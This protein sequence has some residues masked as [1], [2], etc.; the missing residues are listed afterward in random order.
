MTVSFSG[1][2]PE[3]HIK[4]I[5][6]DRIK[7]IIS[8]IEGVGQVQTAGGLDREIQVRLDPSSLAEYGISYQDVCAGIAGGAVTEPAGYVSQRDDRVSLR[9]IGAFESIEDLEN[10]VIPA[11]D[12]QPVPLSLL[13]KTADAAAD[14]ASI[15]RAD[16]RPVVQLLISARANADIVRASAEIRERIERLAS[17]IPHISAV[18]TRDDSDFV[19]TAVKSV[20]RATGI[21]IALTAAVI[22]MFLGT[23]SATFI[24]AVAMPVA[25]ASTFFPMS[26]HGY[27]LNL[28]TTLGLGL[29]MGV[30]VDNAILVLE[31]IYRFRDMGYEPSEAA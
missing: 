25:F 14:A 7:P 18:Y 8:R 6:S 3:A 12:G 19:R 27:S 11:P 23:L 31:N 22:F 10:T 13:G 15:V 29:S 20:I 28:M 30:L 21:G 26:F 5:V 1:D 2:L 4:R 17:E 24:I 9:M 16:G